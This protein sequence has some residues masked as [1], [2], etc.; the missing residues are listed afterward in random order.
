M[1]KPLTALSIILITT[2][3]Y[4]QTYTV[5]RVIDGDTV[6]LINSDDVRSPEIS[7]KQTKEIANQSNPINPILKLFQDDADIYRLRHLKYYGE[8][9]EEFHNKTGKYPFE[10]EEEVPIYVYIA[11]SVQEK[12]AKDTNPNPHEKYSFKYLVETLEQGLGRQ[13][14]EYY[15]PQFGPHGKPNFYIYMIYENTYYFAVHISQYYGFA[16]KIR[17][18]Y[19]KVKITNNPD[20]RFIG[21]SLNDLVTDENYLNVIN[22]KPI[23]ESFFEK[24]AHQFLNET[25]LLPQ[26]TNAQSIIKLNSGKV[27]TGVIVESTDEYIKIDTGTGIPITIFQD[28]INIID[29]EKSENTRNI[30]E[31][32][33]DGALRFEYEKVN[34]KINGKLRR[35]FDT[36]ELSF[37]EQFKEG[38]KEGVKREYYK[39]GALRLELLY[40][41]DKANGL[42]KEYY[43]SGEIHFKAMN[44]DDEYNGPYKEFYKT[45]VLKS[46][47]TNVNGKAQGESIKYY[48]SGEIEHRFNFTDNKRHGPGN[49]Y[50]KSGEVSSEYTYNRGKPEGLVKNYF[51]NGKLKKKRYYKNGKLH[52]LESFYSK[53][54][55]LIKENTYENGQLT[56]TV[57]Y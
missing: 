22:S 29:S 45:G 7:E 53:N 19:Y 15:D 17:E 51:K 2:V 24:R 37:I 27:I 43:E 13:I 20:K 50:F 9:L 41:D 32:Y 48:P 38:K 31:Y 39:S 23:K 14:D 47:H 28:E 42:Q 35:Y 11:I 30:V 52:G 56:N 8:L 18:N 36:G 21:I 44:Q 10:G 1:I 40:T 55:K 33:E 16:N 26:I 46:E 25:K 12:Y 6:K 4:A 34:G 5:E 54:G 57:E 3:S 49:G